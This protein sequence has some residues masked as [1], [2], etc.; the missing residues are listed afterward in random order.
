[1]G[2]SFYKRSPKSEK[3]MEHLN[4]VSS[5]FIQDVY[6]LAEYLL[7]YYD[8]FS[9]KYI[10]FAMNYYGKYSTVDDLRIQKNFTN[11]EIIIRKLILAIIDLR[12]NGF[13][14]TDIHSRNILV[15]GSNIKLADMDHVTEVVDANKDTLL[16][17]TW[18]LIDF[19]IQVYFYDNL[20]LDYD[21]HPFDRF[22]FGC[23]YQLSGSGMFTQKVD[24]YLTKVVQG[25]ESILSYDLYEMTELLI[26]DFSDKERVGEIKKRLL[27]P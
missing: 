18:L 17:S 16:L 1:M 23:T 25:D 5:K 2:D 7:Y 4:D 26:K 22:M 9:E 24:D 19:I 10:G 3:K 20:F 13:I 8:N 6:I 15:C 12:E 21:D 11:R 27:L 14:Y